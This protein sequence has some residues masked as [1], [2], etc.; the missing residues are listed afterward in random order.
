[1]GSEEVPVSSSLRR[2]NSFPS[3]M[4][5]DIP[6]QLQSS[7]YPNGDNVSSSLDFELF[8]FK[9]SSSSQDDKYTSLKDLMPY[10]LSAAIQ[11]PTGSM[12][13]PCYEI[14]IRNRLVKQAAWAYLQ[15]MSSSP[16]SVT[17][18]V[19]DD[20]EEEVNVNNNDPAKY[21]PNSCTVP[22]QSFVTFESRI[23]V[24]HKHSALNPKFSLHPTKFVYLKQ[25]PKKKTDE[26]V[27]E[28]TGQEISQHFC[29]HLDDEVA[30]QL[31]VSHK[32]YDVLQAFVIWFLVIELRFSLLAIRSFPELTLQL[33]SGASSRAKT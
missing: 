17:V 2:R 33:N 9:P 24:S 13:L 32:L 6:I 7:S 16:V 4:V 11:S 21:I 5:L 1:M 29:A 23:S 27:H 20:E 8:S 10:S 14:S 26:E 25:I 3:S 12:I 31:F 18:D 15:P 28:N 22:C 19:S 30:R